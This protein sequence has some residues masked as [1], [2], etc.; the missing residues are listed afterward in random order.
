MFGGNVVVY[1]D[2]SKFS[3]SFKIDHP[4]DPANKYLYH[5]FVESPDMKNIYD[6]VVTLDSQGQA[7]VELPPWFGA[8]NSDYRY[9]LTA[10]GAA[11]PGL[12][13]SQEVTNGRFA[14][15]GGVPGQ[16][17]SWQITGIRQD[18]W[19]KAKRIPVEEEKA[20]SDKGYFLYPEARHRS[21]PAFARA[22]GQTT[23]PSTT[24][25]VRRRGGL[26]E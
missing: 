4:L 8:L 15:A 12:Y 9:Q 26:L 24:P 2:V 23:H 7:I 22:S 18:A 25:E 21:R 13:I 19:A 14:I 5:S 3:G 6:G 16:K 20:E 10:I 17:V 11:A 1:G